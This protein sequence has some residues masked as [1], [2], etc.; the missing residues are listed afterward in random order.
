MNIML[1]HYLDF[2]KNE[3]N[4]NLDE[5]IADSL[6]QEITNNYQNI[7]ILRNDSKKF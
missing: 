1:N 2:I 6:I 4:E 7:S 5:T 3:K